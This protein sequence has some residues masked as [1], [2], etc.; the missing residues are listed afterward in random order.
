LEGR[1]A[2]H[3]E[4]AYTQFEFLIDMGQ[5]YQKSE[6]PIVHTRIIMTPNAAET[7]VN[8]LTQLLAEY[9]ET[10]GPIHRERCQ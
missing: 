7:L 3:F 4:V 10:V 2:N 8:M 5:A 9:K 6:P 1:S